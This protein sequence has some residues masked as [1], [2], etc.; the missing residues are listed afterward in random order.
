MAGQ[1]NCSL[2]NDDALRRAERD[3][4]GNLVMG[5]ALK[6]PVDAAAE[7]PH[8]A[9]FRK[10]AELFP[11][12]IVFREASEIDTQPDPAWRPYRKLQTVA[13]PEPQRKNGAPSQSAKR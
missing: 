1:G 7:N 2:L 10:W 8:D 3:S 12:S 9:F 13:E 11:G 6:T 5:E 4:W